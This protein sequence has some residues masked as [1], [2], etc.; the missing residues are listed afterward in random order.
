MA[1]KFTFLTLNPIFILININK[2]STTKSYVS[3]PAVQA[4]DDGEITKR[5]HVH[6]V[7]ELR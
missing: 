1:C 6:S 3:I 5:F 2:Q 4:P 7:I